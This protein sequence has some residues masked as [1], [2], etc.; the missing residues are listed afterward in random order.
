MPLVARRLLFGR[1]LDTWLRFTGRVSSGRAHAHVT[2]PTSA[3]AEQGALEPRRAPLE[4]APVTVLP[5]EPAIGSALAVF[6]G[7]SALSIGLGLVVASPSGDAFAVQTAPGGLS[8]NV[9]VVAPPP[10][11]TQTAVPAV[12][13]GAKLA[14]AV[15]KIS[16]G[17]MAPY[18]DINVYVHSA[19]VLIAAGK[20]DAK[21]AFNAEVRLPDTLEAGLHSLS[22][23]SIDALGRESSI[24]LVAFSVTADGTVAP[25]PRPTVSPTPGA[26]N[27]PG[28]TGGPTGSAVPA[29][30]GARPVVTSQPV[31]PAVAEAQLNVESTRLANA[32][33]FSGLTV[34]ADYAYGPFVPGVRVGFVVQNLSPDTV[35][36]AGRLVL[37]NGL[38]AELASMNLEPIEVVPGEAR[39]VSAVFDNVGQWAFYTA[40]LELALPGAPTQVSRDVPLFV[41][42]WLA[43]TTLLVLVI[44]SLVAVRA[45]RRSRTLRAAEQ[46]HVDSFLAEA[47]A[48]SAP[49]KAM[50]R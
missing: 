50:S 31:A 40:R 28:V 1:R 9:Q 47:A 39:Q 10:S 4:S 45:R 26:S 29:A 33:S 2:R 21:G 23:T 16:L 30:G 8:L 46:A 42:P 43:A 48:H 27:G 13:T 14:D 24:T 18:A 41:M 32:V 25:A 19:P 17:G 3:P 12:P 36:P 38:G 7:V 34:A 11:P 15:F 6:V 44:G 35:A 5:A 20:A 37:R 22:A 49:E